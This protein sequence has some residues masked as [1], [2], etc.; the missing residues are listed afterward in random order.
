MPTSPTPT[1]SASIG[2]IGVLAGSPELQQRLE[3]ALRADGLTAGCIVAPSALGDGIGPLDILVVDFDE[4]AEA[5]ISAIRTVT[6]ALPEARIVAVW[7]GTPDGR[8]ALRMGARGVVDAIDIGTTL[9]ATVRAVSS[10]LVCI[11]RSLRA[12]IESEALS[13]RE[14]QVLGLVVTGSSNADIAARLFL[15]ESTVKSHLSTAYA[16]L[17][18]SSRK[19]AATRILDPLEGL[20]PGI[21][22]ISS[23]A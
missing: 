5:T 18:V 10:G 7:P 2:T 23:V 19:D 20:G 17:G 13:M 4:N 6:E 21:L 22:A 15:A 16:K 9:G 11:P 14:K 8:R 3:D 12:G 1:R